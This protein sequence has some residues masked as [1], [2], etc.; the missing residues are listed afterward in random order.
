MNGI[1]LNSE[2]WQEFKIK[3][4][5]KSIE[6]SKTYHK[7]N[8]KEAENNG[9][10]YVTRT[11]L[12]NGLESIVCKNKFKT[13]PKNTIVFGAENAK[14]FFQPFEYIT[15]NSMCF[16]KNEN[17]NKHVC[18]F[19]QMMLDFSIQN[20]GFGYGKGLTGARLGKRSILLPVKSKN[21]INWDFMSSF[22]V[23]QERRLLNKYKN[24]LKSRLNF[25][26]SSKNESLSSIKWKEFQVK[27]IFTDIQR[28]KR[29]KNEDHISGKMPYISSSANNNGLDDYVSNKQNVRIF[30]NCL[31]LANSGSVGICFYQPFEFV[32]SD[33]VTK[34]ENINFN[35]YVYLFL[36]TIL[37]RLSEKYSF[38]REINNKRLEKEKIMLPV[39]DNGDPDYDFM[40]N[41]M[42]KIEYDKISK[43]LEYIEKR[44]S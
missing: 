41:Y 25:I 37:S 39:D 19:V 7:K 11:N 15:G 28:G 29:L 2:K 3:D 5:F 43:Y 4:V 6:K 40:E 24:Y 13:N 8:L 44:I 35:R 26:E 38:N 27:D 17:F 20:S 30:F 33:H 31:T 16:I 42:K 10:C 12:N 22:I 34:L 14:F 23:G 1:S 32:A 36:A 18:L 21:L 9:I